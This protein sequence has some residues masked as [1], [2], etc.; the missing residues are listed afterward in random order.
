MICNPSW[1]GSS[2]EMVDLL[3]AVLCVIELG[4]LVCIFI[5]FRMACPV[6]PARA[7]ADQPL[8]VTRRCSSCT[9]AVSRAI[10]AWQLRPV[11]SVLCKTKSPWQSTPAMIG[12]SADKLICTPDPVRSVRQ[13][14]QGQKMR[15]Q[16]SLPNSLYRISASTA[17][18]T[19]RPELSTYHNQ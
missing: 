11:G 18:D 15:S 12:I 6:T 13:S 3:L 2:L 17:F 10:S 5:A 4:S 16:P 9:A 8:A 7:V 14:G 1:A 19:R